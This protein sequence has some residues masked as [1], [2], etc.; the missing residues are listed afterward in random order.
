MS[1]LNLF[2]DPWNLFLCIL[3]LTGFLVQL[4]LFL[5]CLRKEFRSRLSSNLHLNI[6]N[7]FL[8]CFFVCAFQTYVFSTIMM[9]HTNCEFFWGLKGLVFLCAFESF[10]V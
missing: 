4:W 5:Q 7:W 10:T 2:K 8:H 9:E 3:A 1:Q 6:A